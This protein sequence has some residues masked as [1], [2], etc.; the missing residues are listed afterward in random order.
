[1]NIVKKIRILI[2]LLVISGTLFAK[3]SDKIRIGMCSD[4]HLNTMHD[5]QYRI[6]K[7]IDSMKVAKPD[8]IIELGDFGTPKHLK[9]TCQL[10]KITNSL[11]GSP[12]LVVRGGDSYQKVVSSNPSAGYWMDIFSH[13]FVIR[14]AMF[15]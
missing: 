12:S 2:I 11:Y 10:A 7:F 13:L 5:S 6:T 3:K 15:V 4:V 8:F 9:L 14:I 1:M